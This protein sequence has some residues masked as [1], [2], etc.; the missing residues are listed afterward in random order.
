MEEGKLREALNERLKEE[1]VRWVQLHFTD[2]PGFLMSFTVPVRECLEGEAW[3]EGIGFDGSSVKGFKPIET[4]DMVAK[5]DPT[6]MAVLPWTS[7]N[8]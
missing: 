8:Q 7:G 6:T 3:E 1:G 5:P 2:I 4:S